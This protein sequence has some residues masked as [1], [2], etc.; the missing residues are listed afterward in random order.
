M[1]KHTKTQ[2]RKR[3]HGKKHTRNLMKNKGTKKSKIPNVYIQNIGSSKTFIN[4][5]N[6]KI[7]SE[8][9]WLGDYNGE[10]AK[11]QIDVNNDNDRKVYNIKMNNE[12][13]SRLL[14]MESVN[15]P[16]D[17]RLQMDLLDKRPNGMGQMTN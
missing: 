17:K 3:K 10:E 4:A 8:V 7:S 16:L 2:K 11:L 6:K 13:L 12:Q 1:T 14:G 9:K 5:N 15:M